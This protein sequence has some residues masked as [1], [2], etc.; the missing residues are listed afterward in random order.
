MKLRTLL[1][2]SYSLLILLVAI[3]TILSMQENAFGIVGPSRKIMLVCLIFSIIHNV[4]LKT[5]S[6]SISNVLF[7][8]SLCMFMSI[9]IN[10]GTEKDINYYIYSI[11]RCLFNI[12]IFLC[13]YSYMRKY[14]FRTS[15]Y[16]VYLLF[17]LVLVIVYFQVNSYIL[18]YDDTQMI[19]SYYVLFLLPMLLLK[20]SKLICNI[21]L[22]ITMIALIAG[23]KRG[24]V[25]AFALSA[26][27]YYMISFYSDMKKSRKGTHKIYA[28]LGFSFLGILIAVVMWYLSANENPIIERIQNIENDEG[29]GRLT[30]WITTWNMLCSSNIFEFFLGH[31]EGKVL[32][33]SRLGLSAHNDFL[34]VIYDYGL[35]AL[36]AYL[37]FIFVWV[38]FSFR[39]LKERKYISSVS[40]FMLI[41]FGFLSMISHII[42]YP[43]MFLF[44]NNLG[45]ICG[46]NDK[47]SI[48]CRNNN[49]NSYH[50]CE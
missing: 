7:V 43:W 42:I 25:L 40:F 27:A 17:F 18:L 6:F 48:E 22:C 10:M 20:E 37:C 36:I 45:A 34:E 35:I 5:Y 11:L 2:I 38:R 8:L 44:C 21:L 9:S 4:W 41:S 1:T 23:F 13:T 14:G 29:S 16:I 28:I 31:G 3:Y 47:D 19:A 26:T 24:G 49:I 33:D 15:V 46:L 30:V 12:S 50:L 39:I 32:M